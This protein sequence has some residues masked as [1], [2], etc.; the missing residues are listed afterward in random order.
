LSNHIR[1]VL[2]V[3][4]ELP[5]QFDRRLLTFIAANATFALN[6]GL[7][8]RPTRFVIVSLDQQPF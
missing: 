8:V 1:G 3:N 6:A 2:K 4:V 5:G 7:W